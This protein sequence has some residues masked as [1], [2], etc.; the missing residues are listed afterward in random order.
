[1]ALTEAAKEAIWLCRM[2]EEMNVQVKKPIVLWC[3]NQGA[4]ALAANPG[5]HK[6]T[7]HIDIR[8]HYIRECVENGFVALRHVGTT[9]QAA[10]SLTKALQAAKHEHA[11]SLLRLV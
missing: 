11:C 10:D 3:D 2:L 8:Y 4:L 5:R 7:K 1:M 6:R 9:E